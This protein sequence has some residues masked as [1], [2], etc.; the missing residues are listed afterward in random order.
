MSNNINL[1]LNNALTMATTLDEMKM[2]LEVVQKDDKLPYLK[3]AFDVDT[4]INGFVEYFSKQIDGEYF[5]VWCKLYATLLDKT[6]QISTRPSP[7]DLPDSGINPRS[8]ALQ[9]DSLLSEP[10]EKPKE[11]TVST[12]FRI[13]DISHVR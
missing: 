4:A 6:M 11:K 9:E 3:V 7:G 1:Q 13:R 10:L 5:S 2:L 12:W 8:P